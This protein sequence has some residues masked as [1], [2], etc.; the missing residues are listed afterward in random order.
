[1]VGAESGRAL[2]VLLEKE[3]P[4]LFC[5]TGVGRWRVSYAL[6]NS[7]LNSFL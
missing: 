1:M 2:A 5:E 3:P 6:K 7:A 4:D